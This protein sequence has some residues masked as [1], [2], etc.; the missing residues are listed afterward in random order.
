MADNYN[1]FFKELRGSFSTQELEELCLELG[2]DSGEV[3]RSTTNLSGM[4]QD[5]QGY[6]KRRGQEQQLLAAVAEVRPHLDLAPYGYKPNLP[7]GPGRSPLPGLPPTPPPLREKKVFV[8]Y[9]WGGESEEIVNKIDT[10]FQEKG[11]TIVRDKRNLGYRGSIREFMEEIG[12][13]Q[14]VIVVISK[15]Y[16]QSENCMYELT[17]IAA[18][19]EFYDRV[20]PIV[21]ADSEIYK[22]VRRLEYV[23][24]WEDRIQ[25]LDE[26]IR[27]ARTLANVQRFTEELSDYQAIRNTVDELTFILK[28]MNTLTP[29]M[30]ERSGFAELF[31]Q[32][33]AK[34]AE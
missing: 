15:K 16:L 1:L 22:A 24:Y 17:Q 34:L 13:G 30:H 21:L 33:E 7:S 27:K 14:A 29:E 5:L 10:T 20:F 28:D 6:A 3:F 2:Y 31:K 8:S 4:A 19:K 32:I 23:T 18:N 26:A 9:A 12:R 25:E 11:I